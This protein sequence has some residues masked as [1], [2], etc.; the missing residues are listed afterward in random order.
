MMGYDPE[1]IRDQ[2]RD[3]LLNYRDYHWTV[4]GFL[5]AL[6]END[7]AGAAMRADNVNRSVLADLADFVRFELPAKCRGSEEAVKR[8]VE[9]GKDKRFLGPQHEY[10]EGT[11]RLHNPSCDRD[12]DPCL[13]PVDIDKLPGLAGRR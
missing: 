4:G 10:P 6:L 11:L 8:W 3:A 13:C 9:L 2:I 7:L 1:R 12:G 5:T